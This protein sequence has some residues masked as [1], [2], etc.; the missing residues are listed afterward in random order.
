MGKSQEK[1]LEKTVNFQGKT[2]SLKELVSGR[3]ENKN[4]IDEA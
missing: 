2:I 4:K 1:I 3:S